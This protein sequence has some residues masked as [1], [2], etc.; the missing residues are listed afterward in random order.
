MRAPLP[1]EW[2][3]GQVVL[4]Q[5]ILARERALNMRPVLPAFAG[6][7]PKQLAELFPKADIKRLDPW[8]GFGEDY[9]TYF[10]NSED[11]LYAKIQRKFLEEQ[12]RLFG[13]DHIYGIDLFN[14]ME[15]SKLRLWLH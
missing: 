11:P 5:K 15:S 4:Q 9:Q 2:L 7:V 3:D 12:T 6:H 8:D 1:K 10:L 14:E 13:T